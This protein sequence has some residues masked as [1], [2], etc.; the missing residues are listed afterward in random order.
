MTSAYWSRF[1]APFSL[2]ADRLMTALPP[3]LLG[4]QQFDLASAETTK[5]AKGRL[6]ANLPPERVLIRSLSLSAN[7][8][9]NWRG[10]VAERL[11]QLSPW[12]AG[13]YLWDAAIIRREK[14]GGLTVEVALTS[15]ADIQ[16][17]ETR[18]GRSLAVIRL[19]A[20]QG[21]PSLFLR[22][23][24][25]LQSRVE[26]GLIA[27]VLGASL[28]GLAVTGWNM[29]RADHSRLEARQDLAEADRLL[30]TADQP[31]GLT[32]AA[33]ALLSK[34]PPQ[35]A[36]ALT[37]ARL[38][39]RLPDTAWSVGLRIDSDGFELSGISAQ[40]EALVPLL[41][42]DP[43]LEQVQ[44]SATSAREAES[45]LFSFTISGR[46]AQTGEWP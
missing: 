25:W 17:L 26:N 45:D 41:E 43:G 27:L 39:Q 18:L 15:L 32:E 37:L 44:L 21:R 5:F 31:A 12:K 29:L 24:H 14:A 34:R 16:A 6:W 9:A 46:A 10:H 40:P 3:V 30:A 33:M 13:G 36:R 4:A 2:I 23:D 8:E 35:A 42:A 28:I 7:Q 19:A 20:T 11:Q 22:K 38:A 1:V